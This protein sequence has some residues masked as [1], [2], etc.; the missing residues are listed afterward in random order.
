MK[1]RRAGKQLFAA[2]VFLIIALVATGMRQR[3][4]G[5]AN[6]QA[7]RVGG[8]AGPARSVRESPLRC[9]TPVKA[10]GTLTVAA[11]ATYAPNEFIGSERP[12]RGRHGRRHGEGHRT[13]SA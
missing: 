2:V 7:R 4:R 1:I 9:P 8:V 11:D 12:D 3:H 5:Q 6:Q 10:D 13:G